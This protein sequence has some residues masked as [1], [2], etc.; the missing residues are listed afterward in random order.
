VGKRQAAVREIMEQ[1][2]ALHA[3]FRK[4]HA[5]GVMALKNADYEGAAKAIKRE[6]QIIRACGELTQELI[7]L[8]NSLE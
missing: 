3:E 6:G 8:Q 4:V 5:K 1:L 2:A 7:A